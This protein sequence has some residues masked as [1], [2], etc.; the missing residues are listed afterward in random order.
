MKIFQSNQYDK[1]KSCLLSYPTNFKVTNK[2]SPYYNSIDNELMFSQ[3][4]NFINTLSNYGIK[5]NFIDINKNLRHQ[6]FTQDIGFVINDIMFVCKMKLKER[7]DEINY[8]RKFIKDN[9]LKYYCMENNIEG[10]DVIHYEGVLFIGISA[11]TT[12][13]ACRELEKALENMNID[14]KVIPIYFDNSKI[15]LDCVFNTLDKGSAII[16]SYVFDRKIIEEYIPNLIEIS[17]DDADN[18]GTN[19]VYL[20]EKKILSSN[21]N[22]LDILEKRG[23]DV[24]YINYSEIM[25]GEGSLGCSILYLLR[26]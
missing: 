19:Y 10:G 12:I 22:V 14:M 7:E 3:Y 17:K 11:R 18:L 4:N 23:Y 24:T 21:K 25:K 2:N 6:V 20:G 13:D 5:I 1:L 9:N 15:H 16:C 8:L 26:K